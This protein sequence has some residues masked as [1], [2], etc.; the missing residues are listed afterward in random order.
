MRKCA[1]L[2]LKNLIG[3]QL[4][5][6]CRHLRF[7]LSHESQRFKDFNVKIFYLKTSLQLAVN[8]SG[9]NSEMI[10]RIIAAINGPNLERNKAAILFVVKYSKTG[11][12]PPNSIKLIPIAEK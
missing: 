4:S 9:S 8:I 3:A 2:S 5:H 10:I 1:L 11:I 6:K 12:K 7:H